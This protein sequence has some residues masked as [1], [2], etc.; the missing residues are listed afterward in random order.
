MTLAELREAALQEIGI[1][2]SGESAAP[3]DDQLVGRKYAELHD[4]L[5]SERLVAWAVDEDLPDYAATPVT[6][7]LAAWIAPAFGV[8]GQRLAD[9]RIGGAIG[10]PQP[11][12]AE[13]MLRRQLAK[14]YVPSPAK[15]EYF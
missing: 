11:S 12:I 6:M 7:M 14:N 13:R 5:L 4:V 8:Q 2:A 1:L 10:L 9:L 3:E 15:A